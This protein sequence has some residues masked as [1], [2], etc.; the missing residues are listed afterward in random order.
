MTFNRK[1]SFLADE[2]NDNGGKC[3]RCVLIRTGIILMSL[4]YLLFGV[5]LI[6]YY[7][8]VQQIDL[9]TIM[10]FSSFLFVGSILGIFGAICQSLKLIFFFK[11]W[12]TFNVALNVFIIIYEC[13]EHEYVIVGFNIVILLLTIYW[14]FVVRRYHLQLR[15]QSMLYENMNM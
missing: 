3:C 15:E 5:S 4:L 12:F 13:I 10:L 2:S 9:L 6:L 14:L 1:D 7:E 8:L 11:I